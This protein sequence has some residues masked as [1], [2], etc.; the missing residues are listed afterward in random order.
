MH[1]AIICERLG[2]PS[3]GIMTEPFR[4]A[5]ALMGRVLGASQFEFVTITHP[6]SS[7][8]ANDHSARSRIACNEIISILSGRD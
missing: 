8:S 6:I 3:V 4:S 7:A 1:D 5:A 2:I